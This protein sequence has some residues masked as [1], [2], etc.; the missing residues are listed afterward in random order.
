VRSS[1]NKEQLKAIKSLERAFKKCE[2]AG[3]YFYG[4]DDDLHAISR[5]EVDESPQTTKEYCLK[6][7][8]RVH[9]CLN[10]N[11]IIVKTH[12]AYRNSGGF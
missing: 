9:E 1:L 3:I 7:G 5:I 4:M 11:G 12:G 6:G 8:D 2:E 10:E